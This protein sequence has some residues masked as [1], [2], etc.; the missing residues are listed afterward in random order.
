MNQG[1]INWAGRFTAQ[2][3]WFGRP[4]VKEVRLSGLAGNKTC[5]SF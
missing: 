2:L 1:D 3:K 4:F 5:A